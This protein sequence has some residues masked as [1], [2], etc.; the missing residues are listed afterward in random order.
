MPQWKGDGEMGSEDERSL[1]ESFEFHFSICKRL[2]GFIMILVS[3][4]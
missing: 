2:I 1:R 4:S 3:R